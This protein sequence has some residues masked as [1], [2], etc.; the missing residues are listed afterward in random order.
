MIVAEL[1]CTYY[2]EVIIK[3]PAIIIL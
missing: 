1:K 2:V 3:K